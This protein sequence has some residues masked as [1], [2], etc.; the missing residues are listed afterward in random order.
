MKQYQLIKSYESEIHPSV[1]KLYSFGV[2]KAF[3]FMK[4]K[5]D[6]QQCLKPKTNFKRKFRLDE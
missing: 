4:A 6:M 1:Q 2:A 5:K 3:R